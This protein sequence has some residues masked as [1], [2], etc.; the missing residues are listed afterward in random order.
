LGNS[1]GTVAPDLP[2]VAVVDDAT[3]AIAGAASDAAGARALLVHHVYEEMGLAYDRAQGASHY[4]DYPNATGY[5]HATFLLARFLSRD[6]GK[7]VNCTDCASILST[8][9]N[10]IGADLRYAIIGWSFNL[11]PIQGIGSSSFGSPFDSGRLS[12]T[13]HAVTSADST[14]TIHD[15]TLAVDGDM[16]PAQ[17]PYTKQLV[18][19]MPGAEYL[20]RLSGDPRAG[21]IYVDKTTNIA[22]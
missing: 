5:T 7:I 11:N 18:Q 10:M 17:A 22:F 4:T 8:Y 14:T 9:S 1:Q 3:R 19:G 2:W 15:A 6:L 12:F 13:Y 20:K 21:Y 16:T